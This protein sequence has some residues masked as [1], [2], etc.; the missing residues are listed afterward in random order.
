MQPDPRLAMARYWRRCQLWHA[1]RLACPDN[2]S[3]L[4][5]MHVIQKAIEDRLEAE[6]GG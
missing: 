2:A 4:S 6:F 5:N 1:A 3:F